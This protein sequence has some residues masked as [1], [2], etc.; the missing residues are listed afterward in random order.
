MSKIELTEF[1]KQLSADEQ[2]QA[3]ALATV[4][5]CLRQAGEE[6]YPGLPWERWTQEMWNKIYDRAEEMWRESC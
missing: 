2:E 4:G 1:G 5:R 6:L 3:V